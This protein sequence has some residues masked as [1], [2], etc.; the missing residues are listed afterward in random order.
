[1]SNL[2]YTH[3]LNKDKKTKQDI[4]QDIFSDSEENGT[5]E[6]IC[7]NDEDDGF[8][9]QCECCYTWQ[10]GKCV[11]IK[12]DKVP[13]HYAC[14]RCSKRNRLK[15]EAQHSLKEDSLRNNDHEQQIL[16]SFTTTMTNKN[17]KKGLKKFYGNQSRDIFSNN[18]SHIPTHIKYNKSQQTTSTFTNKHIIHHYENSINQY[19]N[20]S[21]QKSKSNPSYDH[22]H[23]HTIGKNEHDNA[24]IVNTHFYSDDDGNDDD[25]D[26]LVKPFDYST[27]S[28]TSSS[29]SSSSPTLSSSSLSSSTSS[30]FTTTSIT[31]TTSKKHKHHTRASSPNKFER[32]NRNIIKHKIV[33]TIMQEAYDKW[34]LSKNNN[35]GKM[36]SLDA[37]SLI[38][39]IPKA[40]ARPLWKSLTGSYTKEDIAIRKGL[41]ADIHIPKDRF[42]LEINGEIMVKSNYKSKPYSIYQTLHTPEDRIFFYPGLDLMIDT[43]YCGNDSRLV[44]R[45]CYPNATVKPIILSHNSKDTTIHLGLFATELIQKSEELCI[46]W[47]WQRDSFIWKLYKDWKNGSDCLLTDQHLL[48]QQQQ[49]DQLLTLLKQQFEDCAC[50]DKSECFID[51]LKKKYQKRVKQPSFLSTATISTSSSTPIHSKPLTDTKQPQQL[52]RRRSSNS[53][54]YDKNNFQQQ[55]QRRR[56]HDAIQTNPTSTIKEKKHIYNNNNNNISSNKRHKSHNNNNINSIQKPTTDHNTVDNMSKNDLFYASLLFSKLPNIPLPSSKP[57]LSASPSTTPTINKKSEGAMILDPPIKREDQEDQEIK[58]IDTLSVEAKT[59]VTMKSDDSPL[60]ITSVYKKW[61][62]NA[63]LPCKKV[64][65]KSYLATLASKPSNPSTLPGQAHKEELIKSN[66][67]IKMT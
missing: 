29:F 65:I 35:N 41:F 48:Q 38:P 66:F 56:S 52:S 2:F 47:Q 23:H 27:T 62:P 15:K 42:I 39:T 4:K 53:N 21:I 34:K 59:E 28:S 16:H 36:V 10:H 14:Y 60:E 26:K 46:A 17:E 6:C 67:S 13:I 57:A 24:S 37:S 55:Q 33:K 20:K 61:T 43:T 40:S 22:H 32:V 12:P 45:S 19:S 8:T 51:Y 5:I 7:G 11:R 49:V 30:P 18:S 54:V 63:N 50:E 25:Y 9:I 3:F 31:A 64:W 58:P 44:R 1:M